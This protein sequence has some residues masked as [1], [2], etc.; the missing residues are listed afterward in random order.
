MN[1]K[2]A[3][4]YRYS[5]FFILLV[6]VAIWLW[7]VSLKEVAPGDGCDGSPEVCELLIADYLDASLPINIRVEDL[8]SRMTVEE[9]IGQLALVD[10][11]DLADSEDIVR[12]NLGALLS[13][14]GAHPEDN[15][16]AGWQAMVVDYQSYAART[17]LKIP[18]LYGVDAVHG[19]ANV[20]GATVFPHQ[21]GLGATDDEDL[22]RRVY[23]ATARELAATGIYWNFAPSLD[24]PK[25]SRWGRTY[26]AFSGF[27]SRVSKLGAA[28]V[29]GLQGASSSPLVLATVK[30]YVGGGA[31]T[32]GSSVNEDYIIDQGDVALFEKTLRAEHLAPFKAAVEAGA[33]SVMAGLNSWQKEK[34]T[35]HTY[36]LT[37][38]LKGEFGF[39]GFVVSDWY[40]V[41][42]ILGNDYLNTV[43]AINA[44]VDLVMLPKDYKKFSADMFQAV[45]NGKIS[46]SRLD[47]A[48]RRVLLA[49]FALGLFER[50]FPGSADL[51]VVGS[52]EHRAL[53]REAVRKSL[54]LLKDTNH[55]LP[56]A[57]EA[58]T[59]IVAGPAADNVG[60]QSGG[61]TV[62]WQGIDGNWLVG[63]TSILAGIKQAVSSST[64]LIYDLEGDFEL[65][66]RADI[67]IAVVGETPYSEG[68][69]DEQ[70]P[71]LSADDLAVI[72]KVRQASRRLVVVIVSG[73]P[74]DIRIA[75]WNWPT[76]VAAWLPGSEGQGVSDVLF[77]DYPF[78][79]TLPISWPGYY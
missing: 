66:N 36:L 24:V 78:T 17:R 9:K 23:E 47:D 63:G 45:Q 32:W 60:R 25:D 39:Q 5:F 31:A 57:K 77:G 38:V 13:G 7:S 2:L 26:E 35:S 74:L 21:I 51:E 33:W 16:P 55:T 58:T 27:S 54:V 1:I 68:V 49:K 3:V 40:G 19:H 10:R 50:P 59:I 12:Y 65:K 4:I 72:E 53:A 71:R 73:R 14:S 76:I 28:A 41:Y 18:L 61:W 6:L 29:S 64:E 8:L 30:H 43:A 20:P 22:V 34:I 79:G 56:L 75:A 46:Y 62:E 42:E 48:V 11:R 69:G 52:Q 44:G 67:G 15:T 37:D 70:D